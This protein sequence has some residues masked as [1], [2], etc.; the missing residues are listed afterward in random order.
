LRVLIISPCSCWQLHFIQCHHIPM[1]VHVSQCWSIFWYSSTWW[2][3]GEDSTS[4][5][6]GSTV[7]STRLIFSSLVCIFFKRTVYV[8]MCRLGNTIIFFL[9][10]ST[11]TVLL[12]HRIEGPYVLQTSCDIHQLQRAIFVR[13]SSAPSK[14]NDVIQSLAF[15]KMMCQRARSQERVPM[16]GL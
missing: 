8:E 12:V 3:F 6:D 14:T 15:L 1:L 5:T 10:T 4:T 11:S 13:I 7:K 2:V 9:A 16:S